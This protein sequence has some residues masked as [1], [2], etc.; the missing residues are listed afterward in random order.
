MRA[1]VDA[2]VL[3]SA[4]LAGPGISSPIVQTLRCGA[5][6]RFDLLIAQE[7]LVEVRAK[8]ATKP[9]LMRNVPVAKSEAFLESLSAIATVSPS[10][11]YLP[12]VR[13]RDRNDDYLIEQ[14]ISFRADVPIAADKNLLE[15][16]R[17]PEHLR[18]MRASD[19][20]ENWPALLALTIL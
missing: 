15:I 6:R 7:S 13:S 11:A 8:L 4:L 20:I 18:I 2:N 5:A 10:L 9:W 16:E 3:V 19:F 12:P 14:A 17:P 1:L